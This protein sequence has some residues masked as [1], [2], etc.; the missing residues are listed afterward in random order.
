M[1]RA[2]NYFEFY[3]PI[4]RSNAIQ[5]IALCKNDNVGGGSRQEQSSVLKQIWSGMGKSYHFI[6]SGISTLKFLFPN[7]RILNVKLSSSVESL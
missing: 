7:V 4:Q 3:F 6:Q 5:D 2:L 1:K